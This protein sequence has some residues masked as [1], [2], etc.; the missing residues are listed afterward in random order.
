MRALAQ[1]LDGRETVSVRELRQRG[2]DVLTQVE[3]GDSKVI[4]RDGVPVAE[5]RVLPRPRK[6]TAEILR[7]ARR[8]PGEGQGRGRPIRGNQH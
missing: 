8:L 2:G 5:L 4:T 3:L 7:E 1:G 6:S